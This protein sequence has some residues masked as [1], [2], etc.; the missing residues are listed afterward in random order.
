[1]SNRNVAVI[2]GSLRRESLNRKL[3]RE[4]AEAV[5][6]YLIE[7]HDISQRRIVTPLGY[8]ESHEVADNTTRD[9]RKQNRRVEVAILVSKGL[10]GSSAISSNNQ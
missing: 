8:G 9:G 1:M 10:T 3:S 7:Q 5:T 6:S 2:V 4:R